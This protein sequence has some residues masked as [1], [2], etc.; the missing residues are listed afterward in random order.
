MLTRTEVEVF[1]ALE[2]TLLRSFRDF[3]NYRRISRR[4]RQRLINLITFNLYHY[5]FSPTVEVELPMD[6][7]HV[8]GLILLDLITEGKT[9]GK[10]RLDD[11]NS[12]NKASRTYDLS[13][14]MAKNI[15]CWLPQFLELERERLIVVRNL[16]RDTIFSDPH[17]LGE[18][19]NEQY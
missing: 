14:R 1:L 13:A 5:R 6:M 10:R 12:Y 19:D 18:G 11:E 8:L 17:L 15:G 2:G 3:T 16:R 4:S 9:L 7:A